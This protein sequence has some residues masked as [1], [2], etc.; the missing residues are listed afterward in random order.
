MINYR[1]EIINSWVQRE[2]SARQLAAL[3]GMPT[4]VSLRAIVDRL[5]QVETVFVERNIHTSDGT[6]I[7]GR[8]A[9]VLRSD[10]TYEFSGHMRAT[11]ATSYEYAVQAWVTC[12]DGSAIAAQQRGN[13]YGTDTPG[14]RQQGWTQPGSNLGIVQHWR[15]LRAGH[16]IGYKLHAEIG[17]VLGTTLD[18]LTFAVKGVVANMALGPGGWLLLIGNELAGMDSKL[19]APSTLAGVLVAGG[20][21]MIVGPFGLVPAIVLGAGAASLLDVEDRAMEPFERD[22][23]EQVFMGSL[24][25]SRIRLTNMVNPLSPG[26]KFTWP[27]V[28]DNILVNIGETAFANPVQHREQPVPLVPGDPTSNYPEPGSL[29]IHEL[30]HAWQLTHYS[31]VKMIGGWEDEYDYFDVNIGRLADTSW[32]GRSWDSFNSEQ[33]AS[34]VDD[35]FGAHAAG[36]LGSFAAINDPAFRFIR[37]DIRAAVV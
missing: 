7:N 27:T 24:D 13:V 3:L 25:Y 18:I 14:E 26:R 15:S 36:G 29:L 10:G 30:V 21:L 17:G 16:G 9:F 6:P 5:H 19:G 4:P 11:G 32:H 1:A 28:G 31:L 2:P 20:T 22:F 37:D 33:Q 8:V 34:I 35:W 12:G 23:A